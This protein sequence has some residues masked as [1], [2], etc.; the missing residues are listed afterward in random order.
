MSSEVPGKGIHGEVSQRRHFATTSPKGL[1]GKACWPLCASAIGTGHW[2]GHTAWKSPPTEHTESGTKTLS[3][4]NVSPSPST[5]KAYHCAKRKGQIFK[6]PRF[7]F[8]E[9]EKVTNLELR[10]YKS[11]TSLVVWSDTFRKCH[12]DIYI[13][14]ERQL[15]SILWL[16]TLGNFHQN[17]DFNWG[18]SY[19]IICRKL[20]LS[21]Y[22]SIML[23]ILLNFPVNPHLPLQSNTPSYLPAHSCFFFLLFP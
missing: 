13:S 10:G 15:C 5:D 6:G 17:K 3:S 12:I 4:S 16:R 20:I 22:T 18:F 21:V 8:T 9:Q 1:P 7:S 23:R 19:P 14:R 11:V 2:R